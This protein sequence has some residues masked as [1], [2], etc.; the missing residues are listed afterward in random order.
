MAPAGDVEDVAML[1]D[2][3]Y[4]VFRARE[5][6]KQDPYAARAWMLTAKCL[7]PQNFNIQFEAYN[8]EKATKHVKEAARCFSTMGAEFARLQ[9]VLRLTE[10]PWLTIFLEDESL[11]RG[12]SNLSNVV[13]STAEG[14]SNAS[15]EAS[16]HAMDAVASLPL[17]PAGQLS[18]GLRRKAPSGRHLHFLALTRLEVLQYCSKLLITCLQRVLASHAGETAL[19]HCLVL[20]QLDWPQEQELATLLLEQVRSSGRLSYAPFSRY[21]VNIDLLEELMFLTSEQGGRVTLDILPASSSQL[22]SQRRMATRGVDKG[23]KEDFRQA[24]RRQVAR[25]SENIESLVQQFLTNERTSLL[26]VIAT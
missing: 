12:R 9:Q 13:A 11:L 22:P 15:L 3:E 1:S 21:V 16:L 25:G 5:I 10:G 23:A 24:M 19:G 18:G 7:F 17:T 8:I 4:L 6:L 20:L 14:S 26:Q 2:E